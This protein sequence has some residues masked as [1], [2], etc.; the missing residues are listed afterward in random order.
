MCTGSKRS[1]SRLLTLAGKPNVNSGSDLVSM[2]VSKIET[3]E[4]MINWVI[5]VSL[6]YT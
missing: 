2:N 4:E 3:D 1:K 5:P 6:I